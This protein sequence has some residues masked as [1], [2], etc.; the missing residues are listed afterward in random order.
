MRVPMKS[1]Y[2]L[3]LI[4]ATTALSACQYS[5]QSGPTAPS[6]LSRSLLGIWTSAGASSNGLPAP[7]TCS[8]LT[9]DITSQTATTIGGKFGGTC[10]GSVRLEGTGTGTLRSA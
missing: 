2:F 7:D 6:D 1:A 5:R 3:A 8:N 9:W 4:A 10:A